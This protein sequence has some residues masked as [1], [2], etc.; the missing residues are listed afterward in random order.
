MLAVERLAGVAPDDSEEPF[1]CK[2]S[3]G[4]S[5]VVKPRADVRKACLAKKKK[6]RLHQHQRKVNA[7][8]TLE[9][10]LSLTSMESLQNGLQPYSGETP[11]ASID[12]NESYVASVIAALILTLGVNG[13]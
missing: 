6:S 10:Y 12:F 3:K 2:V 1:T 8:M 7:A 11:F 13:L 5:L 9:T 4:S